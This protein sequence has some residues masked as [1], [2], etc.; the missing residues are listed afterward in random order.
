MA[1]WTLITMEDKDLSA[2]CRAHNVVSLFIDQKE[3][4]KLD[5]LDWKNSESGFDVEVEKDGRIGKASG[6]DI[7]QTTKEAVAAILN[8]YSVVPVVPQKPPQIIAVEPQKRSFWK[9]I[10]RIK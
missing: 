3:L 10:F 7:A 8:S 5:R 1:S 6:S 2:Y 4:Y 9:R